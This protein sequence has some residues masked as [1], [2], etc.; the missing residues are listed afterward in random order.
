ML[1]G[2]YVSDELRGFYDNLPLTIPIL[3]FAF[4]VDRDL[5]SEPLTA[6]GQVFALDEPVA[7]GATSH[8]WLEM[9]AYG[10]D[11]A[12]VPEG[13]ALVRVIM[14]GDYD[15][16]ADLRKSDRKR[17]RA[18]KDE[19]AD[20][21]IA[22]LDQR[23]P[24]LAAQVEMRD[25]ATPAT[26]ERYTGVWR[27]AWM[28]WQMTPQTMGIRV[29]KTLPGLDDFFMCGTWVR[30]GSLPGAVTSG[31]HVIQIIC[32]GDGKPFESSEP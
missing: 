23:Y 22:L 12:L 4:G 25:V 24:G 19:A 31:R 26:F 21:V 3:H 13:K 2:N 29:S 28:G 9:H 18:E 8:D 1:G 30:A 27:G 11:P 20:K 32:H 5:G 10:K 14:P 15:Y 6:A 16:W 7:I 17:Y